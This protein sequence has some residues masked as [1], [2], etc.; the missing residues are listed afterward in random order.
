MGNLIITVRQ[1]KLAAAPRASAASEV[2]QIGSRDALRCCGTAGPSL[3]GP[4]VPHWRIGK[5]AKQKRK[6]QVPQVGRAAS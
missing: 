4:Q 3:E 2:P 5:T 6:K 1:T